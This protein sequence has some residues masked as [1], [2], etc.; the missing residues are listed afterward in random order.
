MQEDSALH[1][2][3]PYNLNEMKLVPLDFSFVG[4]EEWENPPWR[5]HK[6][7]SLDV[8]DVLCWQVQVCVN[9]TGQ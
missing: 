1:E 9:E 6:M 5:I 4:I 7:P 2:L 3:S 8:T